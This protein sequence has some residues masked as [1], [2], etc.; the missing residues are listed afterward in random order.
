[1]D[2]LIAVLVASLIGSLHCA[3]MCGPLVAFAVGD[4]QRQSWS[5]RI[6][7]HAAYHGGRLFTY[8][9][10][11]A[12]C[13]L[14]GAAVNLGAAR[15]GVY[16]AAG[17][18]AGAMMIAVGLAA[19]LRYGG[20]RLPQFPVPGWMRRPIVA[21][22]RMAF[23][24]RPLSRAL[25]IGLLTALLPCGWLYLFAL[26]AAGSGSPLRGLAVMVAFWSGTVPILLALGIGV[27]TLAGTLGRRLPLFSAVVIMLLGVSTLVLRMRLSVEAFQPP[28][29]WLSA[30][31]AIKQVEA[32]SHTVPPCCRKH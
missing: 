27:Q 21:G 19:V 4:T 29:G 24:L 5:T 26:V 25:T 13:G 28:A 9:L 6:T 17:L 15:L 10:L 16:R 22:Q 31:N 8:A 32:A 11:G 23:A 2:L 12:A 14:V 30:P 18:L 7:L 3:G 20:V 1:M